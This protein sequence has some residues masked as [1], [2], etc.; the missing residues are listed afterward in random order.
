[1]VIS[2]D[3]NPSPASPD[4]KA[5]V[6]AFDS[7]YAARPVERFKFLLDTSALLLHVRASHPEVKSL[8]IEPGSKLGEASVIVQTRT[9]IARWSIN[10]TNQYVDGEG[11]VFAKNYHG[12]PHLQIVD[13]SGLG[14]AAGG[15]VASDRFLGFIG[16]VVSKSTRY[17]LDVKAVTIPALTTRQVALTLAGQGTQYRLSVDRSP[18][19][20]IEDIS[21]ITRS[22]ASSK[23]NPSSVDDRVQGTAYYK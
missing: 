15:L 14:S 8:R 13:E 16:L 23:I 19:D 2:I 11:V 9:P 12:E 20:Q 17:G 3:N 4:T 1:M 21:R 6:A 5:Y 18:G 10:G 22:L 7:Y